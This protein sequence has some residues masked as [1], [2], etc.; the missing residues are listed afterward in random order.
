MFPKVDNYVP[1]LTKYGM[2]VH[3]SSHGIVVKGRAGYKTYESLIR[4]IVYVTSESGLNRQFV[5]SVIQSVTSVF[6]VSLRQVKLI[7]LY[8][9]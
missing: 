5:V 6:C 1:I 9:R 2:D 8:L 4:E 3:Y 7:K